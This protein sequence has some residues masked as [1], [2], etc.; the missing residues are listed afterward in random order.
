[1]NTLDDFVPCDHRGP[2][3]TSRRPTVRQ[4][5]PIYPDAPYVVACGECDE[6]IRLATREEID[7]ALG[8]AE[9]AYN[10]GGARF[11]CYD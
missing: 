3:V 2:A 11:G 10:D 6:E 4:R 8:G 9:V 5:Y 7:D 1:M